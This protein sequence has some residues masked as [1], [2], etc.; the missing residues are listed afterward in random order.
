MHMFTH[1]YDN[2]KQYENLS[3]KNLCCMHL[4]K[5]RTSGRNAVQTEM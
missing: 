2:K 3:G 4:I 5:A 1:T